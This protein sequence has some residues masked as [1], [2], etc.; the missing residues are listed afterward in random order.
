MKEILKT[1]LLFG[2]SNKL[3]Q[4]HF[5]A[6][7]DHESAGFTKFAESGNYRFARAKQIWPTRKQAIEAKQKEIGANDSDYCPQPWLFNT[8]YGGRMG[9]EDNGISDND[10][11]D[12][13]GGGIF[14]ITGTDNYL[15]FLNWLHRQG[16]Y[17]N[18][19]LQT[20][21]DFVRT[22]EGATISAIWFWLAN[23]IGKLAR[24]DDIVSVSKKINGG[25]IGLEERKK[26]LDKYKSLL[27]V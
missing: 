19:T 21:D 20:I 10:G 3:E 25:T 8:V 1:L 11:F 22:A 24:Q 14:M 26:L 23:N 17:L 5:L 18:L 12:Y 6:Q 2:I 16:K 27:G 4:A 13:R 7:A 9:N 15:S